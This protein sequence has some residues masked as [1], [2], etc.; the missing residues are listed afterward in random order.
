M[1]KVEPSLQLFIDQQLPLSRHLLQAL[2]SEEQALVNNDV[3]ALE[4]V[5]VE[6]NKLVKL[7]MTGQQQLR[8]QLA[9]QGLPTDPASLRKWLDSRPDKPSDSDLVLT[10]DLQRDAQ[11]INRSNGILLQRLANRNQAGLSALRGQRDTGI[12]GPTGQNGQLSSFRLNI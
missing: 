9:Q 7:L 4:Q 1:D 5:T 11:E 3:E 2:R 8:R 10:S 12:Y 6:K